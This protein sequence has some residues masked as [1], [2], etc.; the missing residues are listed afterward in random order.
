MHAKDELLYRSTIPSGPS[1][2]LLFIVLLLLL[3]I[4]VLL[5][6]LLLVVVLHHCFCQAFEHPFEILKVLYK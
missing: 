6:L 4:V 1:L 3:L 2:L 5:F